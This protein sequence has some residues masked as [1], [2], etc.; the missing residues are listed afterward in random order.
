MRDLVISE[1]RQRLRGRRW[2]IVLLL[3]FVVLAGLL[4]AV[5]HSAQNQFVFRRSQPLPSGPVMFGSLALMILGLSCLII[6]SL[7]S[8]SINGER[9]RG[10]LAVLQSTLYRPWDIVGAK[11]LAATIISGA[12]LVVTLPL[13][14]WC[15]I[16]RGVGLWRA[17]MVYVIMFF[18]LALMVL[19][20]LAASAVVRKPSLSAAAA[21]GFVFFLTIGSPILFGLSLL[22]APVDR[23][24][25]RHVGWRWIILAPDPVVVLADAA[26]RGLR[27][28][29]QQLGSDPLESIRSSV[30][31]ARRPPH[32][33]IF[34]N[35]KAYDSVTGKRVG[36]RGPKPLPAPALWPIGLTIDVLIGAGAAY[37][38]MHKLRIPAHKLALG[39]RVA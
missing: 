32:R 5:Q 6:P 14:L 3:W 18:V 15:Y 4:Y 30:R 13:A 7:T 39:E 28:R 19:I 24:F 10:T 33:I 8:T 11:F 25:E 26:P 17:L 20:G 34:R 35:G 38:A 16:E 29:Q 36:R 22:N 27:G 37:L 9:D 23:N 2:W 31:E 1:L 12:F 21:Y